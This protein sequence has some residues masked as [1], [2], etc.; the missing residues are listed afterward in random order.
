MS[1]IA[2]GI[3][4]RF[5]PP[6]AL[7][8]SALLAAVPSLPARPS[9]QFSGYV[10]D[11]PFYQQNPR[12]FVYFFQQDKNQLFNLTRLR[13]R[14][15]LNWGS[16]S[17]IALTYE[18]SNLYHLS[19]LRG[20]AVI[21]NGLHQ[22]VR[23]SWQAWKSERSL[24]RHFI[25]RL[26]FRQ[27][28]DFGNLIVGR[29]RISWG[30]GRV[31]NPT[32]LFNPLNPANFAKIEKDGADAAVFKYYLGNFSDIQIVYNAEHHFKQS[33]FAARLRSHYRT[34]DFSLMAGRVSRRIVLGGDFAGN[35]F[36]AGFRGE[37]LFS[38]DHH[39]FQSNFFR[40]ILGLDYQFNAKLYGLAEY[41]HNGEGVTD[42]LEYDLPR[43]FRG[44]ILN[45]ARDYLFLQGTYQLH[46]LL[47]SSAAFNGNLNDGSAF[48]NFT[49]SYSAG[50]NTTI[51]AGAL[52]TTG[53]RFDEFWYYAK[54][55]Y[56]QWQMYF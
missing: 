29:Q 46:P 40:W 32:D 12:E 23:L 55:F 26:Y 21:P 54:S 1:G 56:L 3:I 18:I 2:P 34:Y 41:Q 24:G 9:L 15:V 19:P 20:F 6:A 47:T 8:W 31:W 17:R 30:T 37:L 11:L 25:D 28:F 13:L 38:A 35:L 10:L 43:L 45:V 48:F 33:N 36:K 4:R 44:E 49:L 51:T 53:D 5:F 50:D 39:S 42:R 52:L 16:G 14:P 7:L 27:E 22:A